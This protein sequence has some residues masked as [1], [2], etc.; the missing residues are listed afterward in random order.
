MKRARVATK[1]KK[2]RL[3]ELFRKPKRLRERLVLAIALAPPKG[4]KSAR[5]FGSK[6]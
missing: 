6:R 1:R 5:V 4:R 3:A 2:I